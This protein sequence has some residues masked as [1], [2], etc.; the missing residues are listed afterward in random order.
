M[1]KHECP[2]MTELQP[3]AA[4]SSFQLFLLSLSTVLR[5]RVLYI[6]VSLPTH[7]Q[8]C[9]P[10]SYLVCLCLHA[11]CDVAQLKDVGCKCLCL[12]VS[13]MGITGQPNATEGVQLRMAH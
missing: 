2:Y 3:V 7:V 4:N 12:L 10:V 13:I 9:V 1:S 8:S 6:A 5:S 11:F